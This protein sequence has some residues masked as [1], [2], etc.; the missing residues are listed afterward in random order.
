MVN[1]AL[2][3]EPFDMR[4]ERVPSD[5]NIDSVTTNTVSYEAERD[6]EGA[7]TTAPKGRNDNKGGEEKAMGEGRGRDQGP[8]EEW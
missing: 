7:S 6:F 5:P 4:R 8:Y 2:E 1:D 3:Q